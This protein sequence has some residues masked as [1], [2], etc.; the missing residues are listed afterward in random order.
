MIP[1]LL[2]LW[3]VFAVDPVIN[4]IQSVVKFKN[5]ARVIFLLGLVAW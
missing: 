1:F 2:A 5:L 3:F 4:N